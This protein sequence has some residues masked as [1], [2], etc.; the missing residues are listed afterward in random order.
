MRHTSLQPQRRPALAPPHL[1]CRSRTPRPSRAVSWQA[2]RASTGHPALF[3]PF[4]CCACPSSPC[5]FI[6]IEIS[7]T[8]KDGGKGPVWH[9]KRAVWVAVATITVGGGGRRSRRRRRCWPWP[10]ARLLL[11]LLL[12]LPSLLPP[13][14]PRPALIVCR[15][16]TFWCLAWATLRTATR[17]CIVRWGRAR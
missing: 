7:D 12:L 6:L 5:S 4:G 3:S 2:H 17:H 16:S 14:P 10:G 1:R 9:M 11:L 15:D 8:I 13:P